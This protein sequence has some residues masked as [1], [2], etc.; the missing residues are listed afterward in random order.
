MND[1]HEAGFSES[2]ASCV[3]AC[4]ADKPQLLANCSKSDFRKKSLLLKRGCLLSA[5]RIHKLIFLDV[6]MGAWALPC[7][8]RICSIMSIAF[9][10]SA[11]YRQTDRRPIVPCMS[12]GS[13][14]WNLTRSDS[15][16]VNST[17]MISPINSR[18]LK[19]P[20]WKEDPM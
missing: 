15:R 3:C 18:S 4:V 2:D 20:F 6:P 16:R 10:L 8:N 9:P 14:L 1:I 12:I 19:V 7:V 5:N 11:A 13:F 17:D